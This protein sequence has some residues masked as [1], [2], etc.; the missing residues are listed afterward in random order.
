G[1]VEL[2]NVSTPRGEFP[3]FEGLDFAILPR[4][5]LSMV[6]DRSLENVRYYGRGPNENYV[7][8]CS[9]SDIAYWESTVTD[10]YVEY[11]RPQDNGYKCDVRWAAFLDDDGG[12]VLIKGSVPMYMQ[13]LHYSMG[14]LELQR[15][16]GAGTWSD[17]SQ[18]R[19]YAPMFPRDEVMLNVDLRQLGLGNAS[20]GQG[21]LECYMFPCRREEWSLTFVPVRDGG[22]TSLRAAARK[23]R[24]EIPERSGRKS[25]RASG[26]GFDGG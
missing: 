26:M 20:C 16:R 15:H 1:S 7:D 22:V 14:E 5:G 13:A 10:Q 17:K 2:R 21:P 4:L 23:V 12:G 18:E 25:V 6:L 9:A 3:R 11:A 8:R 24:Q 19:F